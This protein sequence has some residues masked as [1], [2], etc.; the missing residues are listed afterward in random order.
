MMG[1][2]VAF[3]LRV[4]SILCKVKLNQHRPESHAAMQALYAKG[5]DNE[6]ALAL[7]MDNFAKADF[8]KAL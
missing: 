5:N 4:L 6:R 3:E 7:W 2:I 1:G 8:L